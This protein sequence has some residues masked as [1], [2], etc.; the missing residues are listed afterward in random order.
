LEAPQDEVYAAFVEAGGE[1]IVV[2][3]GYPG[4]RLMMKLTPNRLY[5]LADGE[6][7]GKILTD[8]FAEAV[9]TGALKS[10]ST[11]IDL[12]RFTG[13][14]DWEA[15]MILRDMTPRGKESASNAA[16]V[17]RNRLFVKLIKIATAIFPKV[18]HKAFDSRAEAVAWLDAADG[19]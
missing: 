4:A 16:Y 15:V 2:A 12:T 5:I 11:L 14:V 7:P 17:V 13:A 9:A 6:P 8:T 10:R 1:G 18:H 19:T 3:R